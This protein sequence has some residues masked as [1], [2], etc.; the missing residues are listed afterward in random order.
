MSAL[1]VSDPDW[2]SALSRADSR[3]QWWPSALTEA[4]RSAGY[5]KQDYKK[6]PKGPRVMSEYGGIYR[7]P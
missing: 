4:L 5:A 2:S 6:P 1:P 7:T 3:G